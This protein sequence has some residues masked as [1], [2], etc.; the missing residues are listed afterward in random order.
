MDW[1]SDS[2]KSGNLL[3]VLLKV[4]QVFSFSS[5]FILFFKGLSVKFYDRCLSQALFW[6]LW[7]LCLQ[8]GRGVTEN[9][10]NCNFGAAAVK[11]YLETLFWRRLRFYPFFCTLSS[12]LESYISCKRRFAHRLMINELFINWDDN[13][14]F[15]KSGLL[16][17]KMNMDELYSWFFGEGCSENAAHRL[18]RAIDYDTL[19]HA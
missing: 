9:K 14:K 16:V 12:T 3:L 7:L 6:I 1:S 15:I 8:R 11:S 13:I 18:F 4:D 2:F 10:L 17:A 19:Q 5:F